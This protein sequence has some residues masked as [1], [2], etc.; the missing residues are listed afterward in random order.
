M[1]RSLLWPE[2]GFGHRKGRRVSDPCAILTVRCSARAPRPRG[3]AQRYAPAAVRGG[4]AV[5]SAPPPAASSML[6]RARLS[7]VR[8]LLARRD[9]RRARFAAAS[10]AR[11]VGSFSRVPGGAR[12]CAHMTAHLA[13]LTRE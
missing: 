1:W 13:S 6:P 11:S 5:S 7:D 3:A 8:R 2:N 4:A 9:S 10:G 12:A